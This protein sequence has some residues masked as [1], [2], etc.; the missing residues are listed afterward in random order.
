[1][2]IIDKTVYMSMGRILLI[3]GYYACFCTHVIKNIHSL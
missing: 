3:Q 1:M 2:I